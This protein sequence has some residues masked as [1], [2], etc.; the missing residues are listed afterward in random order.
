MWHNDKKRSF[1]K[2]Y[3]GTKL[4]MI[5]RASS[6]L[7]HKTRDDDASTA[8]TALKKKKDF[9]YLMHWSFDSKRRRNKAKIYVH[10]R[11][12]SSLLKLNF[13]YFWLTKLIICQTDAISVILSICTWIIFMH[14]DTFCNLNIH[15]YFIFNIHDN[16]MYIV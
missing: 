4:M 13:I 9:C 15:K 16:T 7:N 5:I 3:I 10:F 8:G 1:R 6:I 14:L 11:K 2:P 12:R